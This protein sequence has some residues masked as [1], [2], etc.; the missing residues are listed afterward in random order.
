MTF[1]TLGCVRWTM[2]QNMSVYTGK[3]ASYEDAI[4]D[5]EETEIRDRLKVI[6][7]RMD[8]KA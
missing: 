4:R 7:P 6:N 2:R 8:E 5:M 1:E 3:A